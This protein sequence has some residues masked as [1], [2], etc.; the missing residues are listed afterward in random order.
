MQPNQFY[1]Q[2]MRQLVSLPPRQVIPRGAVQ[3]YQFPVPAV[4]GS[5][6]VPGY[7][8]GEYLDQPSNQMVTE[9]AAAQQDILLPRYSQGEYIFAPGFQSQ[10]LRQRSLAITQQREEKKDRKRKDKRKKHRKGY[11]SDEDSEVEHSKER[12]KK[13]KKKRRREETSESSS[14]SSSSSDQSESESSDTSETER[15]KRRKKAK[16]KKKKKLK[17]GE[18]PKDKKKSKKRTEEVPNVSAVTREETVVSVN[19]PGGAPSVAS[20]VATGATGPAVIMPEPAPVIPPSNVVHTD[21]PIPETVQPVFNTPGG[22]TPL[23]KVS[24]V[25]TNTPD[26]ASVASGNRPL[27]RRRLAE[28]YDKEFL[29]ELTTSDLDCLQNVQ[30]AL[31]DEE[32]LC[33]D[34][35]FLSMA[36]RRKR[37]VLKHRQD[38]KK[39]HK[40]MME[41]K[42]E[43]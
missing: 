10:T 27:S 14:S 41:E 16:Q 8:A 33:A 32:I 5:N 28:E 43:Q 37:K 40:K 21:T 13:L 24:D 38:Q 30:T 19:L 31:T 18:S 15:K 29:Q 25:T 4:V 2:R 42:G 17:K 22:S 7:A 39:Y 9:F 6:N 36:E 20:A 3:P 26:S 12:K 34:I 35:D 23:N 11:E 1:G